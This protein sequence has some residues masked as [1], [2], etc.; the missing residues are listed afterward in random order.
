MTLLEKLLERGDGLHLRPER[1]VETFL[2]RVVDR[3]G[4]LRRL[5]VETYVEGR[6]KC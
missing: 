6:Y 3:V 5:E 1:C 4:K 2:I